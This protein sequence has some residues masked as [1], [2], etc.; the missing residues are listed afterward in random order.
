M[1]FTVILPYAAFLLL[2]FGLEFPEVL[3][4]NLDTF[5]FCVCMP[6]NSKIMCGGC[7]ETAL[8]WCAMVFWIQMAVVFFIKN[9]SVLLVCLI[10]CHNIEEV[11]WGDELI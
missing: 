7:G 10:V 9:E 4:P 5:I 6:G 3:D 2:Y 8:F 11:H 1:Y